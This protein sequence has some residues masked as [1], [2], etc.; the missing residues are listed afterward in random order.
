MSVAMNE[1]VCY[2]VPGTFMKG[3]N[4]RNT[5]YDN[6]NSKIISLFYI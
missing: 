4:K 1:N 3:V 2:N 6:D 5:G